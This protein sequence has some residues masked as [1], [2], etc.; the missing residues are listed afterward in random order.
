MLVRVRDYHDVA[1]RKRVERRGDNGIPMN[2]SLTA[3]PLV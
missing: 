2:A 1:K 3:T